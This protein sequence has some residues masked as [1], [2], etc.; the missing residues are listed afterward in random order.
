MIGTTRPEYVFIRISIFALRLIAPLSILYLAVSYNAK[1]FLWS[2]FLG[3]YALIEAV[4]Y[5][6]VYLPRSY[7]LQRVRLLSP[8][9]STFPLTHN[10]PG[11]ETPSA[12]VSSRTGGALP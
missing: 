5:L 10:D 12:H 4:F 2:P 7:Y 1:T 3:V 8:H 6:L 9:D 11:S